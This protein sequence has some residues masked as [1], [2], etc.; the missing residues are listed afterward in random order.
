MKFIA[1]INDMVMRELSYF[2]DMDAGE[3]LHEALAKSLR[4]EL[5]MDIKEARESAKVSYQKSG[6]GH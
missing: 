4:N 1:E 2:L 3:V 5:D 6:E